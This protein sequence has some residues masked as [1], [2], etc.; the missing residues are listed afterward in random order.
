M[1]APLILDQHSQLFI[2]DYWIADSFKVGRRLHQPQKVIDPVAAPDRPWEAA[3]VLLWGSVLYDPQQGR[4]RMWYTPWPRPA[5]PEPLVVE[6]SNG[7]VLYAESANGIHWEKPP[8]GQVIFGGNRDNNIVLRMDWEVDGVNVIHDPGDAA[9][10]YKMLFWGRG[11]AESSTAWDGATGWRVGRSPDGIRWTVDPQPVLSGVGD[12]TTLV[13]FG[14]APARGRGRFVAYTRTRAAWDRY[15]ARTV[16]RLE[17]PDLLTWSQPQMVLRADLRD[18]ANMEF[19]GL[20]AFPYAG[21]QLG[22]VERMHRVPD[23]IDT[24]L[25]LSRD[26]GRAWQRIPPRTAFLPLG[27][28]GSW[29]AAWATLAH[30]APLTVGNQLWFY[31]SGRSGTHGSP[32]PHNAGAI[33]LATLRRDGFASIEAQ[34]EPGWLKTHPLIWPGGELAVN[35]D[36][37]AAPGAYHGMQTGEIR[38]EIRDAHGAVVP[39]YDRAQ[40]VPLASDT[41]RQPGCFAVIRWQQDRRLDALRGQTV[42]ITFVLRNAQLYAFKIES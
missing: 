37:R 29:D 39:G 35:A 33:G 31:Y 3:A 7:L 21:M 34:H 28:P 16:N 36:T 42:T 20:T 11:A 12:R 38:V 5:L 27:T 4:F 8:V 41:Q 30:S 15:P 1:S 6:H 23:V 18:G 25:V 40:C 9:A 10:P 14:R 19:Y 2:D 22:L 24:E 13:D 26:N 17:S 32:Y